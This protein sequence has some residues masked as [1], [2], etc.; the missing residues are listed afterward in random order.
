M[1]GYR[2]VIFTLTLALLCA[3]ALRGLTVPSNGADGVFN[4]VKDTQIDLSLAPTL[5]WDQ[6]P[7]TAGQGVYDSEKWAVV[8]KYSS[9]NIPAGVK[10]TFK[11]HPSFA[12]V[13][14][15]V[16]GDVTIAGELNLDGQDSLNL[17]N[18]PP[19][20]ALPGPGGFHSGSVKLAP[21]ASSTD[22]G[23]P[24]GPGAKGYG[25]SAAY[26]C[27]N[28][29][30]LRTYGNEAI[31]PLIGGSGGGS[32]GNQYTGSGGGGAI[33]IASAGTID[34]SGIIS[35]RGGAV[36]SANTGAGSGGGVRLVAESILGKGSILTGLY[37]HQGRVRIEANDYSFALTTTPAASI[38]PAGLV[39]R[40]WPE[41]GAPR[42]RSVSLDGTAVPDDPRPSFS[43]G[44]VDMMQGSAG[45]KTLVIQAQNVPTNWFVRVRMVKGSGSGSTVY[46]TLAG[47]NQDASTW[48]ATLILDTEGFYFIQV[49]AF[50]D[51]I[52]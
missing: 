51:A 36:G 7:T 12:P 39:A 43:P 22:G 50:Q 21:G 40:I 25:D 10:I 35:A 14:W 38:A 20:A 8:F 47:G 52:P 31:V 46:A 4:P 28:A 2:T 37:L 32:S 42:I 16:S 45:S 17:A 5:P 34:V 3:P 15:L 19:F 26:S 29:L 33:L 23:W 13:V 49:D 9:V 30:H 18:G 27:P 6:N 11:N 1:S 41:S 24:R 44:R 48:H